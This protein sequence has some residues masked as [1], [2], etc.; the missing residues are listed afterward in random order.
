[1]RIRTDVVLFVVLLAGSA[2]A[3]ATQVGHDPIA[4]SN[5][6]RAGQ[7]PFGGIVPDMTLKDWKDRPHTL[8]SAKGKVATVLYFFSV[9]CPCVDAVK[10]RV[11]DLMDTYQSKGVEFVGIDGHPEDSAKAIFGKIAELHHTFLVLLDPDQKLVRRVGVI[12]ATDVVVLDAEGRL[13][14]R[15]TLDDDL[16]KPT[17]HY[18]GPVLAALVKGE[19]PPFRES[20]K[21]KSY[22]CAYPGFDG[23]CPTLK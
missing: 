9:E 20:P 2:Y 10:M 11:Q 17:T 18:V 14:Y 4:A 12:G 3:V 7:V 19:E 16:V 5:A 23:P 8:E 21:K 22:G 13:V 6:L 1:M 15:G